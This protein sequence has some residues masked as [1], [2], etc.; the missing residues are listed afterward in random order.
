MKVYVISYWQLSS[1][2]T[3]VNRVQT[4][5]DVLQ[6]HGYETSLFTHFNSNKQYAPTSRNKIRDFITGHQHIGIIKFLYSLFI[7]LVKPR[8][9]FSLKDFHNGRIA[10]DSVQLQPEDIVITS[11]PPNSVFDI[12]FQLKKQFGCK[13]IMDY[14]DPWTYGYSLPPFDGLIY[15]LKKKYYRRLENSYLTSADAATTVSSSLKKYYPAAYQN[16]VHI[17]SN[18]ANASK[19]DLSLIEAHPKVFSIVYSGS[20]YDIQLKDPSFFKALK[21]L[22]KDLALRPDQFTLLFV[23]SG[24]NPYLTTYIK[25]VGLEAY[26]QIT[27]RLS[28]EATMPY[29]YKACLFLHLKYGKIGDIITSKNYD[30]LLLQKKILLPKSDGGDLAD[31][32]KHY[33]AGYI[34]DGEQATYETLKTLYEQHTAGESVVCARSADELKELERHFQAQQLIHL[35][36]QL[37][38]Q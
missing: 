17:V 30:Y 24:T 20:I 26:T 28:I 33:D 9:V 36:S 5:V 32:L 11:S 23:G 2:Q 38:K 3:A 35:I 1:N 15:R 7:T 22:I 37:A 29:M 13:W 27:P 14:R 8:E 10:L 31:T 4:F 12:G 25:Q 16:K 34:C 19:V 6:Q 18:G 21:R